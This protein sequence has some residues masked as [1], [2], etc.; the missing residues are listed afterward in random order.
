MASLHSRVRIY[1]WFC[2][3]FLL[4]VATMGTSA[5]NAN[6]DSPGSEYLSDIE[7]RIAY[8]QQG[9]GELGIDTA[10]HAPGVQPMPLRIKRKGYKKGLGHHAP[11]EIL[12]A[13]DGKYRLF[14]A[15][16]GVQWQGGNVGSVGFEVFV[17]DKKA[18]RSPVMREHDA[19]RA[20]RIPVEGAQEMRLV[21]TDAGDGITCDCADWADA[22]LIPSAS[23][24][25]SATGESL[26][27]APFARVATWDPSRSDGCR[28]SRIEEFHA[29]DLFLETEIIPGADGNYAVAVAADGVGCIG[30]Q[31][32]ERRNLKEVVLEFAA[33]T[34]TPSPEG[35]HVE[36]WFG[37]SHW[38]GNWKPLVGEIERAGNRWVLRI[39]PR[40]NPDARRGMS[41][42][43]WILPPTTRRA[44]VRRL[45]AFTNS[46]WATAELVIEAERPRAG[47]RAEIELYNGEIVLPSGAKLASTW[48]MCAPMR[49]KVRYSKPRPWKSDRT[50]IRFRTPSGGFGVA[51]DDVL[52]HQCVYASDFGVY[53][54]RVPV[55]KRVAEYKRMIAGRKTILERVREM[56]DQTLTQAMVRARNPIQDNGPTM[57]SLACDNH[58]FVV[59][60]EGTVQFAS[61]PDRADQMQVYPMKCVS[62]IVPSF[63]S[64]RNEGLKRHLDGGWL[65]VP[66]TSVTAGG[67]EYRE[68]AFVVAYDEE[69]AEGNTSWLNPRP[70]CAIEFTMENVSSHPAE[71]SLSLAFVADAEKRLPA[72]VSLAGCRAIAAS[73]GR[74]LAS[75]DASEANGVGLEVK[76]GTLHVQGRLPPHTVSRCYL[77]IPGWAMKPE[78]NTL[79]GGGAGLLAKVRT[80]WERVVAA[81]MQIELPDPFL[82]DLIR[83]SQVH[84]LIAARNEADGQRIAPWIASMVYGPLESEAN[85]V[86]RGMDLMG[87]D[88]FARRSLD[89]FVRRYDPAGFLTTGYTLM[90]TGWHLWSLGEHYGLT[91]DGDWMK[92]VAPDVARAC[93]WIARQREK[94][95]RLD[96]HGEKMPECGLVPPG[97]QAD[98]NAFAYHFSLEGYYY[99][100][101]RHAAEALAAIGHPD[102]S[103][104]LEGAEQFRREILRAY[105]WT[106]SRAPV[107]P[108]KNGT[109]V[110]EY[111][112]QVHCP[113]PTSA[114]FPGEDGN[115]SWA[116]DVELG[117]HQMV[118]QGILEP[119]SDDVTHMMDHMEDVQFLS[120]GLF[121]YPA[122]ESEKDW[123]NRGGFS[124][125]QPYYCRNAEIYALRDDVKPFIR[126]YFNTL[127]SMVNT[128]NLSFWEHFHNAGAWNKTHETGYFLQQTR[129]TLVMERGDELWIA[130]LVTSNWMRDG[131][132]VAVRNAPT[133]FGKL[134]YRIASHVRSGFI[135]AVI[136]PPTRP[137]PREL[138]IRL[139]HPEGKRIKAVAVNGAPHADFDASREIVRIQT[140]A[141]RITVKAE[142]DHQSR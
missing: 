54:A 41:K 135:E 70:L 33:D 38:Q 21:V 138:V 52:A 139:R 132:V 19:A 34:A 116:Y 31:W 88:E 78:E 7:H 61:S 50:V 26:D 46:R 105:G 87:H 14:E 15:E 6:R 43:R 13:L 57:I 99:G 129:F 37:E 128:E 5:R 83:A 110:P 66:V 72:A 36:G 119:K 108:L 118:P 142:Y 74:L 121:D 40:S 111:P 112:G 96:P 115:R 109:W 100:G 60:R 107:F 11:G 113:G 85:S 106:R 8:C 17:D 82:M 76:D 58:K 23:P 92:R 94:T 45:Q 35:A 2:I 22:R 24:K 75:F 16:I 123:F 127:A 73:A 140:P 1:M 56:P 10:A 91:R 32:L 114:F 63:G 39:A 47:G 27:V 71:P 48:D 89:F 51:A 12:V 29:E 81:A 77:Y 20:I 80:Y 98:W 18:Y 30:L 136:E 65:P 101:L 84:C 134:S 103:P 3:P 64:G 25:P 4:G 102:G 86:I 68:R 125:V 130:P 49:L 69:A 120:D 131:M 97:V 67:V 42:I 95:K 90:G 79:L 9:W 137:Q 126:S 55:K 93:R 59:H 124:K 122:A 53:V 28:A 104:L 44:V 117:A 62:E 141:G 133:R